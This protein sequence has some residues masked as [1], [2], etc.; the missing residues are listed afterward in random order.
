MF[1]LVNEAMNRHYGKPTTLSPEAAKD[2]LEKEVSLFRSLPGKPISIPE[3]HIQS[4]SFEQYLAHKGIVL[5]NG[6]FKSSMPAKELK[7]TQPLNYNR[8]LNGETT[9]KPVVV[10]YDPNLN[11]YK[12]IDG[13][14]KWG[15][16]RL[17]DFQFPERT[18]DLGGHKID[19]WVLKGEFNKLY[20]T[21]RDF[22]QYSKENV[23]AKPDA[24]KNP[25]DDK[26]KQELAALEDDF[27]ANTPQNNFATPQ[28]TPN[29]P[30]PITPPPVRK[31]PMKRVFNY[32]FEEWVKAKNRG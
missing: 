14:V 7:P 8:I 26:K 27:W 12:V 25:Q 19:T 30:Q 18:A 3:A 10:I 22:D 2:K 23:L 31:S 4:G 1:F 21:L 17:M 20:N 13:H 11:D 29:P 28:T 16:A 32:S 15:K 5:G 24:I 9:T 6:L